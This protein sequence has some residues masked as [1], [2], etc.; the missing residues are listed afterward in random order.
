MKQ[1]IATVNVR[2]TGQAARRPSRLSPCLGVWGFAA[3]TAGSAPV[4]GRW[5]PGILDLWDRRDESC[6]VHWLDVVLMN[7]LPAFAV[8]S[9]LALAMPAVRPHRAW[10]GVGLAWLVV[11]GVTAVVA[12]TNQDSWSLSCSFG[13]VRSGVGA[14]GVAHPGSFTPCT[15]T[16]SLPLWLVALPALLGIGVLLSWTWRHTRPMEVAL[17]TLAGLVALAAIT[18]GVAQLNPNAALLMLVAL[19][20]MSH[21]WPRIRGQL[22]AKPAE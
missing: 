18:V 15:S 11:V 12:I 4:A 9:I 20:A 22:A 14:D 16:N 17:R 7:L 13:L 1:P 5:Q 19:V 10:T 2:G 3:E 6:Q 8:M 21:A